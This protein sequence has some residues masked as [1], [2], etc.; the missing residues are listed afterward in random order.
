VGFPRLLR[1][2]PRGG[3]SY[4]LTFSFSPA[5]SGETEFTLVEKPCVVGDRAPAR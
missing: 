1:A 2:Q 5:F 3:R 4:S